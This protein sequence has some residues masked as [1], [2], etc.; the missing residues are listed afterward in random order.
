MGRK[1]KGELILNILLYLSW[2]SSKCMSM[3]AFYRMSKLIFVQRLSH[4]E[5]RDFGRISYKRIRKIWNLGYCHNCCPILLKFAPDHPYIDTNNLY[6]SNFDIL[7]INL[8][9]LILHEK[10]V[11]NG[12]FCNFLRQKSPFGITLQNIKNSDHQIVTLYSRMLW[13]KFQQN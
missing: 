1:L 5:I 6:I 7:N 2:I 4:F 9:M 3:I 11:E 12:N 8:S 10:N 13:C